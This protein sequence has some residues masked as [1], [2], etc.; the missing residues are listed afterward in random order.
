MLAANFSAMQLGFYTSA[1]PRLGS[2]TTV[3]IN[4]SY[5][6]PTRKQP[7]PLNV[8]QKREIAVRASNLLQK[9]HR[10]KHELIIAWNINERP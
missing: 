4:L 2:N 10:L 3:Q 8:D 1:R 7:D 6:K 5:F 9:L